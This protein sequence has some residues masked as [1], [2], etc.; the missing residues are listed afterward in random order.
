MTE[1]E[2]RKGIKAYS[3]RQK[4][5][6]R[7][8][9]KHGEIHQNDF[10]RIFSDYKKVKIDGYWHLVRRK[11]YLEPITGDTFILG[12]MSMNGRDVWLELTQLMIRLGLIDAKTIGGDVVYSLPN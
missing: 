12:G 10:D 4:I 1:Q 6:L 3:N 7:M 2:I 11:M 5:L 9:R 8:I